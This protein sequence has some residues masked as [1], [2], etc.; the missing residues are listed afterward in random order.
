MVWGHTWLILQNVRF[1]KYW[2]YTNRKHFYCSVWTP[3]C[4]WQFDLPVEL[5]SAFSNY[6]TASP[7]ITGMSN[8]SRS[9]PT[10]WQMSKAA[11]GKGVTGKLCKVLRVTQWHHQWIPTGIKATAS[12][13]NN[14]RTE[15]GSKSE[16]T[17]AWKG[18]QFCYQFQA[19]NSG[20]S[21]I[22]TSPTP[23]R[24]T[25]AQRWGSRGSSHRS[26]RA[27]L[28]FASAARRA[29]RS[30]VSPQD[31]PRSR[32]MGQRRLSCNSWR[33]T[34]EMALRSLWGFQRSLEN[35]QRKGPPVLP[36]EVTP[37]LPP[38]PPQKERGAHGSAQ[39]GGSVQG[40]KETLLTTAGAPQD[41]RIYIFLFKL[42]SYALGKTS[43]YLKCNKS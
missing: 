7:G 4:I 18:S 28:K 14:R 40:N 11:S 16:A 12:T 22:R 13:G 31:W 25:P 23:P 1:Y 34:W 24:V 32:R 5:N 3:S 26:W 21:G 19:N 37:V 8:P 2:L 6:R 27:A 17:S 41:L 15:E 42:E 30:A 35:L 9:W 36:A 43:R 33:V 39:H 29:C 20:T 38:E 10:K